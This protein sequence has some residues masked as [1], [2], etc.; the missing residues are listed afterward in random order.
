M[1]RS[2]LIEADRIDE[3]AAITERYIAGAPF[4]EENRLALAEIYAYQR[5]DSL[6]AAMLN[7]VIDINPDNAD[8]L[9]SLADLYMS[10][11]RTSMYLSVL[12]QY[13]T[14]PSVPLERKIGRLEMLTLNTSFYRSHYFEVGELALILISAYP[15]NPEVTELY[16]DHAVRGGNAEGALSTL[17][18][19]LR[20][21]DAPLNLF[22][23]TI[24]I[25]AWL[26]R[27]D[28]VALWSDRALERFPDE[29][30]IHLL[31]S[32]ALQYM[33]RPR[34]ARKTLKKALRAATTDSLRSEVWGAIG[35]LWH[36]EGNDRKTFSAYE[37]ALRYNKNNAL[38]LNNYAYFLAIADEQLDRALGM[39]K[40][41]IRLQENFA[42]YLDTY[43]WVLYKTG[44]YP[45]A[46][47]VMQQALPLDREQNPELL[48]HYGDI[49]WALGERFMAS[50]YWRK[51]RDAGWEPASEI[52]ERLAR[53][54]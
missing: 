42:T 33:D 36:E 15:G 51:A 16:A 11:G 25:E 1:K 27:P 44:D 38:V 24:E 14:L 23:K 20:K 41:A 35:T 47:R 46:R 3:A 29:I 32:S 2:L 26:G 10:Q 21:P 50:S 12:K 5:R 48:M 49:L 22:L 9:T 8:A 18:N 17:K 31:R 30:R 43:A 37:N 34:E 13:F 7:E 53:T 40:R 45:E 19:R 6:R 39:A 28:S 52:E 4:D 54:E